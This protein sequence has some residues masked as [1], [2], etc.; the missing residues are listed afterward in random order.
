MKPLNIKLGALP[1]P[2]QPQ[3]TPVPGAPAPLQP[4]NSTRPTAS[5]SQNTAVKS[6]KPKKPGDGMAK[7]D[8]PSNGISKLKIFMDGRA[9]KKSQVQ[10]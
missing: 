8:A 4:V 6:P 3:L 7:S 1:K 10:K 5:G 2:P 9:G